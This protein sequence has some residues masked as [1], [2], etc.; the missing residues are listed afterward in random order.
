MQE[1]LGRFVFLTNNK[2]VSSVLS[3]EKK[4]K[5]LVPALKKITSYLLQSKE[6][7]CCSY[8]IGASY[9]FLFAGDDLGDHLDTTFGTSLFGLGA[10]PLPSTPEGK[11]LKTLNNAKK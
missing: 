7:F 2:I 8:S 6:I 4:H 3:V 1:K 11:K 9:F 5:K 10:P